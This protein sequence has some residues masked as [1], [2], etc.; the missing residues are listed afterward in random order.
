MKA[1]RFSPS[2]DLIIVDCRVW[3]P[4]LR[5]ARPARLVV[6]TGAAVTVI[7]PEILDE[8][9][10]NPRDGE[11][12]TVMRSAVGREQGYL[13]RVVRFANSTTKCVLVKADSSSN[14]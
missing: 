1:T 4:Q 13:I 10:Y 9:G 6:D 7:V 3:G 8:L 12:I 2:D 14:V 5:S 11:A